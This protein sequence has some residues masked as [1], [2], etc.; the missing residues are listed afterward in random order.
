MSRTVAT[1]LYVADRTVAADHRGRRPCTCGLPEG[2]QHH[3]IPDTS[4]AQHQ[5]TTRYEPKED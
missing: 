1:H 5:H 3:Q 4:D 2:N